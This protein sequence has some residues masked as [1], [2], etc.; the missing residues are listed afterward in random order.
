MVEAFAGC[1]A[2]AAFINSGSLRLNQD[3]AAGP[4]TR[5][6]V[7]ELF[8]YETPLYLL[9]ID[10]ATLKKVAE[11]ATRGWPGSG[12][13]LQVSGFAYVHDQT[14]R[15]ARRVT[16]LAPEGTRPVRDDEAILAVV[17]DYLINPDIGDQDGYVMLDRS[18]V[19]DGCAANGQDL[20]EI[21]RNALKAAGPQGIAPQV[22][23]RICQG[24]N[25]PCL[26]AGSDGRE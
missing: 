22:E 4:V 15:T 7:E 18:Q 10:G 1:G 21:I 26:A 3:L 13:W 2:R 23:G 19:V 12:S 9:E 6:H 11:H 17:G 25:G 24:E 20:K 8:A 14:A 5:R 16:L